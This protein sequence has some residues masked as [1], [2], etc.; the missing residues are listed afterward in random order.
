MS[1]TPPGRNGPRRLAPLFEPDVTDVAASRPDALGAA[2]LLRGASEQAIAQLREAGRERTLAA[3]DWLFREGEPADRLFVVLSGR[4]QAVDADGRVLREVGAGAALG[5]LGLLTGSARSASVRAV[6][7]SRLLELDAARFC[8]LVE[9]DAGLA[10]SIARELARQLQASGGLDIPEARPSVFAVASTT[11][12]TAAELVPELAR[13]LGRFGVVK[14]LD[15]TGVAADDFAPTLADAELRFDYVLLV[16]GA[17][18]PWGEFCRRQC[19]RLLLVVHDGSWPESRGELDD[20]EL[21][22]VGAGETTIGRWLDEFAPRSH[23]VVAPGSSFSAGVDRVAR[24][25]TGRSLGVVLSG[26]GARGMAHIGALAA[27]ADAGFPFD[28]IGGCSMGSFI[29]AMAAV[30]YEPDEIA[31]TCSR[32]LVRR[33]PFNDYT[34]P[35]VSLIRS[36]KTGAMLERVFG[37]TRIEGLERPLF[38][39]SADLLSS[40]VFVHRRGPIAEAVAASMTLPGL[41]PPQ[42]RDGR[43]LVDGGVLN[44]LPVDHMA[45]THEGPIVAV[46]VVR[47][48]D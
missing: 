33:T 16:D 4:L 20:C 30:G 23:H 29:S 26:G 5:E 36:R 45:E 13:A 25:L 21:V 14:T 15:G 28:R 34:F 44:N 12:G 6:R 1:W 40:R 2:P 11:A 27:L 35:R 19:D 24:R 10:L 8:R 47:R 9:E 41:L 32:E 38:A 43:L 7:D 17:G 46:D 31:S 18:P 42:Q 37:S 39:V 3:R 48:L 22:F